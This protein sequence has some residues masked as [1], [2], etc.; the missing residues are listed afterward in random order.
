[1][2]FVLFHMVLGAGL[3]AAAIQTL[4]HAMHHGSEVHAGIVAG[5]EAVGALLFLIPKTVKTGGV[6]LLLAILGGAVLHALQHQWR[7]DLLIYA[8]GVWLVMSGKK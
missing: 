1:M 2:A 8:S 4:M 3:L 6:L 5:I 7:F